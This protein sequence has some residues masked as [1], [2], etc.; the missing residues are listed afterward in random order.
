MLAVGRALMS[1]PKLLMLD[2]P[3]LGLAPLIVR[4]IFNIIERLRQ[5]GTSILLIEQNL[6]VATTVADRIAVMVNG[7]LQ[8]DMA[9]HEL[10]S[11]KDLQERLLGLRSRNDIWDEPEPV[12][13]VQL[14]VQR[15]RVQRAHGHDDLPF[16][17]QYGLTSHHA[18]LNES[19]ESE[20]QNSNAGK[21]FDFPVAASSSQ[22]V[23]VAGT[24]DTKGKELFF[25][26]QCLEKLGLRV[27]T[28]DLSTS[29]KPSPASVH[30][31]EVARYHPRGEKKI[32]RA[33][34]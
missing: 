4:E 21:I 25:L 13:E 16:S 33:H 32:G 31:R 12:P 34:V 28:V 27:V 23:Y 19:I 17:Q 8:A 30:P 9:A 10:A 7:R 20:V 6:G 14:P 11:D 1:T 24:F 15:V 26:R 29:G 22:A 2:E 18:S 3:S 5:Q